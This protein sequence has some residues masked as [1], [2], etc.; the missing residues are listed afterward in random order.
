MVDEDCSSTSILR[1]I[2]GQLVETCK[3]LS[4][5]RIGGKHHFQGWW[6]CSLLCRRTLKDQVHKDCPQVHDYE[7]LREL[8]DPSRLE[9]VS[10]VSGCDIRVDAVLVKL[11][12]QT[13]CTGV[14]KLGHPLYN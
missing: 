1:S 11:L 13:I 10:R 5:L 12:N 3:Q 8:R 14:Y 4:L 7:F 9:E 2:P 6:I